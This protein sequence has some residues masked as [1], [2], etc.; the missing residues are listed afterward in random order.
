[1][2]KRTSHVGEF[3]AATLEV[4]AVLSLDG[5]LDGTGGGVIDT[6]DGT[7]DQLDLPGRV[8]SQATSAAAARASGGLS[9]APCLG[10]GGLAASVRGSHTTGHAKGS[11]G[12]V[13]GLT[14]V[15]GSSAVGIVV[16]G[17][18]GV[19]FG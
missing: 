14:R 18:G 7:L 11:G 16:R 10:R 1:M 9:L 13:R 8:T 6:Q 19:G 4:I 17:L 2:P 12:I 3:L 15:D 5:I